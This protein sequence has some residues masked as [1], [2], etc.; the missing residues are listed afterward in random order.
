MSYDEYDAAEES[1]NS[2]D[3]GSAEGKPPISL[4]QIEFSLKQFAK[5]IGQANYSVFNK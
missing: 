3:L 4:K 2:S 5:R 1:D